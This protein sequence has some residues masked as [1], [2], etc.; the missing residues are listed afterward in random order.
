MKNILGR[1]C[2]F[3]VALLAAGVLTQPGTPV[4]EAESAPP[5]SWQV[6]IPADPGVEAWNLTGFSGLENQESGY[7]LF[8]DQGWRGDVRVAGFGQGRPGR[9]TVYTFTLMFDPGTDGSGVEINGVTISNY[10]PAEDETTCCF[11]SCSV[12]DCFACFLNGVHP[13]PTTP[14]YDFSLQIATVDNPE[15]VSPAYGRLHLDMWDYIDQSGEFHRLHCESDPRTIP[16]ERTRPDQWTIDTVASKLVCTEYYVE[17]VSRPGKKG[18]DAE[19][20]VMTAQTSPFKF[21]TIWTRK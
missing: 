15:I 1:S 12:S 3:G 13:K 5:S 10:A 7:A 21:E 18:G 14:M 20:I 19:R 6:E 16:I 9:Q 17:A 11:P 4:I 2:T 8:E